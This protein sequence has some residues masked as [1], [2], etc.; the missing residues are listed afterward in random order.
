MQ[1]LFFDGRSEKLP[2]LLMVKN[3][4]A[5]DPAGKSGATH[6]MVEMMLDTLNDEASRAELES[7]GVKVTGSV[8]WDAIYFSGSAPIESLEFALTR[9]A[10]VVVRPEFTEDSMERVK[11]RLLASTG[12]KDATL[13]GLTEKIFNER[14]FEGNPYSHSVEASAEELSNLLLR[15]VKIQYRR[16]LLPNQ[17]LLA[18]QFQENREELFRRLGRRWGGWVR[19]NPAPFTF[20]RGAV[21]DTPRLMLVESDRDS[22]FLR[23][24]YISVERKSTD[25]LVLKILEQYL[26][27]SLPDWAQEIASSSQ[28]RGQAQLVARRMP[29]Y[30][31]VS[32]ES[33]VEQ[34]GLYYDKIVNSV[35]AVRKG[36]FDLERFNEAKELVSHEYVNSF[37]SPISQ[38][39]SFLDADLYGLGVSYITT[40]NLRLER[41]SPEFFSR[42]VGTILPAEQSTLLL[43]GPAEKLKPV[44]AHLG[45]IEILN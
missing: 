18:V 34:L 19:S 29:G 37:D 45:Q 12:E 6:L 32:I 9:L 24:G 14:L 36:E 15:D 4:A 33:P 11:A 43:A 40:F 26:T 28:I 1:F 39:R 31:Q 20:R 21:P 42:K 41:V 23:W 38:I 27:L 44:F 22:G 30:F 7:R 3:G 8:D 35:E 13:E 25:F 5:F 10:E 16:L 17:A 2:F